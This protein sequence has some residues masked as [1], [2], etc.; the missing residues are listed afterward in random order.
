MPI[1]SNTMQVMFKSTQSSYIRLILFKSD[2]GNPSQSNS[3]RMQSN[4]Y[5]PIQFNTLLFNSNSLQH[6][7]RIVQFNSIKFHSNPPQINTIQFDYN[8]FAEIQS[9]SIESDL[10]QRNLSVSHPVYPTIQ[11]NSTQLNAT[12]AYSAQFKSIQH[13]KVK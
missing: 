13:N 11:F 7:S 5:N 2:H 8:H 10:I 9:M 1:T 12:Q 3:I 4:P 6:N